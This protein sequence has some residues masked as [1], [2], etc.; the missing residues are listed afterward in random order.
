MSRAAC[1]MV[2]VGLGLGV[3]SGCSKPSELMIAIHTD[4]S[5]PKDIDT[6]R[7]EVL[8]G[9]DSKY[10]QDFENLGDADADPRLPLT[11]G[12][13]AKEEPGAEVR[14][15]VSARRGGEAGEVRILREAV[16]TIPEERVA[17]LHL[18]LQFLCDGSGSEKNDGQ[19][20][21]KVCAVGQTCVAGA[22]VSAA[23][24]SAALSDY[25]PEDVFG[26]GSGNGDGAC[27]DV[28]SCFAQ[29]ADVDVDSECAFDDGAVNVALRTESDGVC[30]DKGCLVALDAGGDAGFQGSEGKVKLRATVCAQITAGKVLGVV[31]APVGGSCPQK[32]MGLPICRP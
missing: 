1:A 3:M 29:G 26:G 2:V 11:L 32:T 7:L 19:V 31:A 14:V 25:A 17:L 8:R 9:D 21:N 5:L 24:D 15:R 22:C 16:T 30:G 23:V 4:L 18:P 10:Q 12:L 20:E 28:A 27:F 6:I 13:V